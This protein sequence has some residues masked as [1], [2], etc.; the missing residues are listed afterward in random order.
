MNLSPIRATRLS[1]RPAR[2]TRVRPGLDPLEDRRLLSVI[3]HESEPNNSVQQADPIDRM[4]DEKLLVPT[5]TGPRI[6][7]RRLGSQVP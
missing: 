6:A 3:L 7:R 4:L 1:M 2:S 5:N